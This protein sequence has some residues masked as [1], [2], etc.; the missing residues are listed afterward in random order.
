MKFRC[1]SRT[2]L[3]GI[4]LQV[5]ALWQ[6]PGPRVIILERDCS[7]EGLPGRT[8]DAGKGTKKDRNGVEGLLSQYRQDENGVERVLSQPRQDR[9]EVD[10]LLSQPRQISIVCLQ[11]SCPGTGKAVLGV[12]MAEGA[13]TF[14][15]LAMIWPRAVEANTCSSA[16]SLEHQ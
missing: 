3:S 15:F 8:Q 10:G 16:S 2:L 11:C 13:I 1:V 5:E 6:A 14:K 12:G 7:G 4:M 9:K